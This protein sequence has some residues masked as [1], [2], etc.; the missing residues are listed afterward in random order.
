MIV[1]QLIEINNKI[2]PKSLELKIKNC[3]NINIFISNSLYHFLNK[4]KKRIDNNVEQW[5]FYKKITNP[6]E[7]IHTPPYHNSPHSVANY[8]AISRSFYKL[9]EMINYFELLSEF[10]NKPIKSF[11]LAEGPGGFIEAMIFLRKN[12]MNKD[13][14]YYG[15]T[16]Q[17]NN[18]NIPKWRKLTEKFK[19][20]TSIKI[21]NGITNDGD[22][23]KEE[24]FTHCFNKYKNSMDFLTADGGFDFSIDYEKQ[25]LASL[26]LIFAQIMYAIMLQKKGGTFILKI[27]DIF[28]RPSVEMIYL[29][30]CFYESV[31]V[32]KPNT[33][34]FANSE[35]Y[36]VCRD[37]RYEDTSEYYEVFRNN[38][39]KFS[40]GE[41][42]ESIMKI[43]IPLCFTQDIEEVCAILGKKQLAT[44]HTTLLLI[45]EK[46]NDKIDKLKKTNIEKSIKWCERNNIPYHRSFK[47]ENVFTKHLNNK[48]VFKVKT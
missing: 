29:L 12:T 47:P 11:H 24:N 42:I 28:Y 15:I 48:Q 3:D 20:N 1:N 44:I 45:Q 19:F 22:L 32:C 33:S 17:S 9:I 46:R 39:E 26:K 43:D 35:K 36:L 16:L 2:N 13:D 23:L 14:K 8:E 38:L 37:F 10:N 27:F 5:D 7:F 21:E 31:S 30:N 34:R 25:E 6:Y 41:A 40:E 4:S 18:R